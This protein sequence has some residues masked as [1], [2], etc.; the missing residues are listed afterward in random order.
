MYKKMTLTNM[1][2]IVLV[3]EK[4]NNVWKNIL[5]KIFDKN[6]N[7]DVLSYI[8]DFITVGRR[9]KIKYKYVYKCFNEDFE[10]DSDRQFLDDFL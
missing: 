4:Y 3:L 8:S 9:N 5:C 1:Q 7:D 6:L 2:K 10:T